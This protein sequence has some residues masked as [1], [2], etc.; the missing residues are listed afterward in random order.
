MRKRQNAVLAALLTAQ[1]FIIEHAA[2]IASLVDLSSIRK[3]LDDVIANFMA[4]AVEQDANHRSAK[5]ETE[6]QRQIRFKL[7]T[8]QM[9]PIAEIARRNLST[10]PEFKALRMPPRSYK[11]GAF[12]ASATAM[13]DAAAIQKN[14]LM[15]RGLPA[16]FLDQFRTSLT[17]LQQS[18]SDRS[19]NQA[20]RRGATEGLLF[21]E[22]EGRSVLKVLDAQ[23]RRALSGDVSLLAAWEGARTIQRHRSGTPSSS[24]PSSAEDTSGPTAA[25][26]TTNLA[27]LPHLVA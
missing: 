22:A 25:S 26:N 3:R 11:G 19:Q 27:T 17:N 18:V 8:E 24:S 5:G 10:T 16:D 14:T 4:N 2:Q 21:Q 9:L 13:A 15:E 23:V 7:R 1:R 12:I 6:K 20:C